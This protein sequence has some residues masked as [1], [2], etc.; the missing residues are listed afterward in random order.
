MCVLNIFAMNALRR[1]ASSMMLARD[2]A[3]R[4]LV[5]DYASDLLTDFKALCS[6]RAVPIHI[7][8]LIFR[9]EYF[10]FTISLRAYYHENLAG[11][12]CPLH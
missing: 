1:F 5:S 10:N 6:I 8:H 2:N 9:I 7:M 3:T 11:V 12:G 4:D